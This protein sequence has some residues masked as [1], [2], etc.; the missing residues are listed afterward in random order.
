MVPIC[1]CKTERRKLK[2]VHIIFMIT[3]V[4][5][6]PKIVKGPLKA[7]QID[8]DTERSLVCV[9]TNINIIR[10]TVHRIDI[11]KRWRM[12]TDGGV[13]ESKVEGVKLLW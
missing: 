11:F 8:L 13:V 1:R 5:R 4:F 3:A 2:Q 6:N 10:H 9:R 12:W 7:H